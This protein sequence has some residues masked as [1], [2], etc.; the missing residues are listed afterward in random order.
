MRCLPTILAGLALC[1]S[2]AFGQNPIQGVVKDNV[3]NGMEN[4][5]VRVVIS[6]ATHAVVTDSEGR[7]TISGVPAGAGTITF[8]ADRYVTVQRQI[9]V[10][11]NGKI[12]VDAV[13]N[14]EE[15][16]GVGPLE[17]DFECRK[18]A[19]RRAG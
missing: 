6:G 8:E 19:K 7:Y 17:S 1:A 3:G 16:V 10:P 13:M 15:T 9:S 12:C 11:Q 5:N 2:F 18:W 14:A 4:V